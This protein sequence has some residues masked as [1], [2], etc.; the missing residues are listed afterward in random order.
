MGK[1]TMGL[2]YERMGR[3]PLAEAANG[4]ACGQRKTGKRKEKWDTG[5]DKRQAFTGGDFMRPGNLNS[6]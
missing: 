4:A 5:G 1:M 2:S 3:N 6:A